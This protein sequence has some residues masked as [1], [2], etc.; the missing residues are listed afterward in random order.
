MNQA[1]PEITTEITTKTTTNNII[2]FSEI[3]TCLNTKSHS[4]YKP[5]TKKTKDLITARW[6]EGF[7]LEDF[8]KVIDLKIRIM[9]IVPQQ[10]LDRRRCLDLNLNLT[11][12]KKGRRKHTVKEI[13]ILMTKR[14]EL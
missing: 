12:I 5:G 13:L 9:A 4:S 8:Q 3:I 11:S 14:E 7:T 6:N 10:I 2:P 1:I